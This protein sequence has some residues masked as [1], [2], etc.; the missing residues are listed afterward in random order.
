M[1]K[2]INPMLFKNLSMKELITVISRKDKIKERNQRTI[3]RRNRRPNMSQSKNSKMDQRTLKFEK[4]EGLSKDNQHKDNFSYSK[5]DNNSIEILNNTTKTTRATNTSQKT[6]PLSQS[7]RTQTKTMTSRK[8]TTAEQA[9]DIDI[10]YI[11]IQ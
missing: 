7:T 8:E 2:I 10:L 3:K 9:T 4:K 5:E 1:A 6:S 11:P